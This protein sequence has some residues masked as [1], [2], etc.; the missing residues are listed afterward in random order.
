MA[1]FDLVAWD[2]RVARITNDRGE[3]IFEQDGVEVPRA[4]SQV[5]T[6]VVASRY[7][8]G[9]LGSPE[10]ERSV[11]QMIERVVTTIARWGDE[12]GY[13]A[14]PEDAAVFEA[15]LTHLV[16]H[17]MGSFNSPLWR[18]VGVTD[19]PQ[20]SACFINEVGDDIESILTLAQIEAK[21]FKGGGGTGTNLSPLRASVE[22]LSGGGTA[23]G[24]V[25]FMKGLDA[26]AGVMLEG[27]TT[28]PAAKIALLD[29]DHPDVLEFV[30]CKAEAQ[31]KAWALK[32]AGYDAARDGGPA[33]G[34]L[35]FQTTDLC[36][37]L[38]DEFLDAVAADGRWATRGRLDGK[39]LTVYAARELLREIAAAIHESGA[40]AVQFDTTI[41]AWNT[42]AASGRIN[43]STPC[44]EFLFLDDTACNL[45]ALN[46]MAFVGAGGEVDAGALRHAVD[47]LVTAQDIV[48]DRATYP[49]EAIAL[50][51]HR[52][53]PLGVGFA[54]LGALLL[55]RGLPYDSGRGRGLAAAITALMTGEAYAQG[56]R[57][58]ERLGPFEEY[59]RNRATALAVLERH[60]AGLDGIDA[61]AA[62]PL[63]EEAKRV[64]DEALA[65]AARRG[66]RNAQ[67]TALAPTSTISF[68]MDCD[69]TGVEPEISLLKLR[70]VVGG[71]TVKFVS[72]T[73]VAA[74]AALGYAPSQAK[75]IVDH[76]EEHGTIED[77]PGLRPEHLPVFDCSLRAGTGRRS[78]APEG[79][80]RMMAALQP[81]LSGAISK[82]V[83]LLADSTVEEVEQLILEAHALGLKAI[84]IHREGSSKRVEG[85][86]TPRSQA[87][88]G[89]DS[90]PRRLRLPDERRSV[91]HKFSIAGHEGYIT[92]GMYDDLTPGEIFIR[93]AKA[94]SVVAGLMDSFALA[95]SLSLQYGVPLQ[96]LVDK[97]S[98]SRFEPAGFTTNPQIPIAKSITDYIFRWLGMK[99]LRGEGDPRELAG[100]PDLPLLPER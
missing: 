85:V 20:C 13:F 29:I 74:L 70:R 4:W 77:A 18:N 51:S 68:M 93:M 98:H 43:A 92:V 37:R 65:R 82:T 3:V 75:Q 52:F 86:E 46:L 23:S 41:N 32:A 19:A 25:S 47:L 50:N 99:F 91:T 58:A 55:S 69:T 57:M 87:A 24:P 83:T 9:R 63:V 40:P 61:Q 89:A 35:A 11:R 94:G 79:H 90:R 39:E 60:A 71:D 54:N 14:T 45:S 1:P 48:V 49:T 80:L 81:F 38:T 5:A 84:S 73:V 22:P 44:G 16:L 56:A 31:R 8:S 96:V 15:E 21:L 17:Q 28:R 10:R 33:F 78:I 100:E 59:E 67:A 7:F 53:R 12:D 6:N 36:V 76:A 72:P 34:S 30:R 62:A 26:F 95:I 88:S 97:Y 27:G 42:C 66:L 2:R 64:W